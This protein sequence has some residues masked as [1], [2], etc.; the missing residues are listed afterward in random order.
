MVKPLF[1]FIL[2][3][4]GITASSQ[5]NSLT[6][7]AASIKEKAVTAGAATLQL[8]SG[9]FSFTE[10]PAVDKDGNVYFSDQPNNKIWKYSTEGKLSVFLHNAGRSNGMYF[11]R[12]GN[13]VTCAD[14]RNELWSIDKDTNV[15]VLLK[16]FN[17]LHFNGPNDLWMDK[18]AASIL[19]IPITSGITGQG[20]REHC[21]SSVCITSPKIKSLSLLP[22]I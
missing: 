6:D 8:I 22:G 9:Q 11:D 2:S 7:S 15:S 3:I 20:K 4:N 18:K 13:L 19:P 17:G 10:G 1:I 16:D 5:T 12:K 21:H 14:E